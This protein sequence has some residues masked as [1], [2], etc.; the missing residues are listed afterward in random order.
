MDCSSIPGWLVLTHYR[1]PVT[2]Q[3]IISPRLVSLYSSASGFTLPK[4]K[5]QLYLYVGFTSPALH[6]QFSSDNYGNSTL[7][8]VLRWWLVTF[9]VMQ[10]SFFLRNYFNIFVF[11]L[12][13]L[14]KLHLH[15]HFDCFFF[16]ASVLIAFANWRED[17]L[18]SEIEITTDLSW[19][20]SDITFR[21]RGWWKPSAKRNH[22][23]QRM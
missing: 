15:L 1:S 23:M 4:T 20:V 13:K 7:T 16:D 10:R 8:H 21:P 17:S 14:C 9:L 2:E 11:T 19:F 6:S 22:H 3:R 12:C 5:R 18:Q